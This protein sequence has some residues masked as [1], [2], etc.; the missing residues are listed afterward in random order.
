MN[1]LSKDPIA[2]SQKYAYILAAWKNADSDIHTF[3]HILF[4]IS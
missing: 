1:N 3:E 2:L 4:L